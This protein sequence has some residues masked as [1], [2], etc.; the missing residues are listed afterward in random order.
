MATLIH[1]QVL[2]N[3]DAGSYSN[4]Y[5]MLCEVYLESQSIVNNTSVITIKRYYATKSNSAGWYQFSS[6]RL[7]SY[8]NIN[9]GG[10]SNLGATSIPALP[11]NQKDQWVQFGSWTGTINHNS[12]GTQTINVRTSFTSGV[13]TSTYPY[14]SKN[15]SMDSGNFSLPTIAR[16]SVPTLSTSSF[17]IGDTIS[18]NT[19]RYADI[20]THTIRIAFGNWSKTLASGI[21]LTCTWNTSEDATNLYAQIPNANSGV[22]TIYVDTYSGSTLIGT[23]SVSFTANVINSNPIFNA[24]QLT[25]LD[26]NSSVVAITEN[27]QHIV[28]NKSN[29][30]V[31]FTSAIAQNSA[32]IVSY[33]ITFNGASQTQQSASTINY[34]I[35]N[36]SSN[37]P[38]TIR[39]TDSRGNTTTVS[40]TITIL[41]WI[42]PTAVI[43]AGRVNNY[44]DETKIK[45]QATISSVNSKNAIMEL[46]YR[47]KKTNEENWGN[48]VSINNNVEAT[49]SIDKNYAWNFQ[50]LIIDKFGSTTYNFTIAKGM[51]IM[52]F[53]TEKISVGIN[54][55]P[56]NNNSLD[57]DTINGKSVIDL[58][59]PVGAIYLSVNNVNPSTLFG[60]TWEQVKDRFLLGAGN[61]YSNGSTGGASTVTLTAN[62]MPSHTH[63]Q[64]SCTNPG[65]HSHTI[66]NVRSPSSSGSG[67]YFESWPGGS[68]SRT[69]NTNG[70]GSHTHTITLNYTGGSQAHENMPPYLVVFMWKRTG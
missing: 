14:M 12:D 8:L 3:I 42:N 32:S 7:T 52:F 21:A 69:H 23:N 48:Y 19:N 46:K 64:A 13:S 5:K 67:A 68:N 43:T 33:L 16:A 61:T 66:P 55:F 62:Q 44:E 51:P 58:I 57:I 54:R 65:N 11:Q 2:D 56:T 20:F 4:W 17:N 35:V 41:D 10:W 27:N 47:C 31:I 26:T 70:S 39:V 28:R 25:Y 9:S 24:S 53:D 29:L 63:T 59:Y 22:G 49:T 6:P 45:A 40:K 15:A 37:A 34:G 36:L 60:G 1:S 50:V 18:I 30:N 38:V